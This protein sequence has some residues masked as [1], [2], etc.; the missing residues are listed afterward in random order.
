MS[1]RHANE[2]VS[3]RK[4]ARA[5]ARAAGEAPDVASVLALQRSIGNAATRRLMRETTQ[6]RFKVVIVPD[7]ET[8][9][10]QAAITKAVAVVKQELAKVSGGS[11]DATVRK[12]FVVEYRQSDGDLTGLH[13]RV[14][15]VYL[16]QGKDADKAVALA[17]P[18]LPKG[19]DSD[20]KDA[21]HELNSIGGANLRIDFNG[22]SPSV[23]LASTGALADFVKGRDNGDRLAGQLLGEIILHEIGHALRAKHASEGIMQGRVVFDA[24]TL[25]KPRHFSADSLTEL[26]SRLKYLAAH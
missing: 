12:G 8:G 10:S 1:L 25:G 13:Q 20:L 4:R 16:M 15:L 2:P 9:L 5:A 14:F 18:H 3:P 7:G 11:D 19:Y 6:D 26:R 22:R 21:A 23:S 24:A 17:R